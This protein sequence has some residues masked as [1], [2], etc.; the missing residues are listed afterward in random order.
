MYVYTRHLP[1]H[2]L[3]YN[4]LLLYYLAGIRLEFVYEGKCDK[5]FFSKASCIA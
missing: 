1:S 2:Y 5:Y 4:A 3:H